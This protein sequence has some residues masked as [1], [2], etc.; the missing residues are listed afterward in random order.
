MSN[1][2]TWHTR[3]DFSSTCRLIS[4]GHVDLQ[5]PRTVDF[6]FDG[7]FVGDDRTVRAN[8]PFP[9]TIRVAVYCRRLPSGE[10]LYEV[11]VVSS[12]YFEYSIKQRAHSHSSINHI[13]QED[14]TAIGLV[15]ERFP[16]VGR[17]PG[18]RGR[19]Y[20]YHGDD[21][22]FF[23]SSMQVKCVVGSGQRRRLIVEWDVCRARCL[24]RDSEPVI[25]WGAA[26]GIP[27]RPGKCPSSSPR[28]A[29]WSRVR[30]R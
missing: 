11:G 12:G 24:G 1:A 23:D 22:R 21:G 5:T 15:A 28:T 3:R 10:L 7:R 16:L 26:S 6:A 30:V 27:S 9:L 14:M 2:L 17:Q 19:S 18:W 25:P 4:L 20:G 29:S 13:L 8:V